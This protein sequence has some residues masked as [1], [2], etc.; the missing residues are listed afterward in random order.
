MRAVVFTGVDT[1]VVESRDVPRVGSDE[2]LVKSKAVGICHSDIELLEGRYILPFSY[3]IVPGHEW[4]G[5][6]V[7]VGSEVEDFTPGDRVV[8]ECVVNAGGK[9]HF[10]FTISGAMAE[11]FVVKAEWLHSFPASMSWSMGAL[12]EPFSVAYNATFVARVDPADRVA[13]LGGGPIGLMTAL[14][15]KGRGARVVLFE[16]Q[17]H[18]RQ[19]A[20]TLGISDSFDS[21]SPSEVARALGVTGGDGFDVVL[22]TA[23]HPSAMAQALELAGHSAK[24]VFVGINVG[25]SV[26]TPM[27]LIQAKAL[28]IRGIIGS[29][30]LWPQTIRFLSSGIV[31]PSPIVSHHVALDDAPAAFQLSRGGGSTTKVHVELGR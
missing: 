7:E 12:V 5:E 15:A 2:V 11:Y 8:G 21:R 22:E 9:D 16:P 29:V 14:A 18:R 30:G 1:I 24:V 6:V 28:E 13:V 10:G 31:D 17:E 19:L 23:G 4:S 20:S 27:G 25:G 3:P 26:E